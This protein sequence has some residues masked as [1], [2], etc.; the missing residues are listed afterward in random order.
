MEQRP[1]VVLLGVGGTIASIETEDGLVPNLSADLLLS[2]LPE[3]GNFCDIECH[4]LMS[5]DSSNLQPYDWIVII[6]AINKH[7]NRDKVA[8]VVVTHG[9]DTM[10]FTASA[11]AILIRNMGKPVV[12]TGSQI[13]MPVFGS[14]ARTNLIDSIRVAAT[15]N[16]AESVICFDSCIF[17]GSRTIKLREYDLSAFETVNPF[18]IAE[19]A[20]TI[21]VIDPFVKSRTSSKSWVDGGLNPHVA[22][23]RAFPGMSPDLLR[24]LPDLGYEGVVIEGFGSGNL[25]IKENSLLAPI[26]EL[27]SSGIPVVITTQCVFGRTELLLYE[28]GK[29]FS[30]LGV[31]SGLDM[32]SEVALIKLMWAL[33]K[34]KSMDEISALMHTNLAQEINPLIVQ[35]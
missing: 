33:D 27:T 17:R 21:S 2:M 10:A 12:F 32:I 13:P 24:K 4:D 3:I 19:I 7:L 15:M 5:I 20:R 6:K 14:D 9:T 28:T 16:L 11:A 31:I 23:I 22:L 1:L 29:N 25:P 26:A 34:S 18:P 30:D 35:S 8:G